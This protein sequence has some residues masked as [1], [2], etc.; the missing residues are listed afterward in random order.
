VIQNLFLSIDLF[1]FPET[2]KFGVWMVQNL[3]AQQGGQTHSSA[4]PSGPRFSQS[5]QSSNQK[6]GSTASTLQTSL[7]QEREK[8]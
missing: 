8:I 2:E 7:S 4:Q 3:F 5:I 6:G 1:L